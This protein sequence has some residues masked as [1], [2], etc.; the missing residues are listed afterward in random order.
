MPSI[1]NETIKKL[2]KE[3]LI[4]NAMNFTRVKSIKFLSLNTFKYVNNSIQFY[5]NIRSS[6]SPMGR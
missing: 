5:V 4:N 2:K 1:W 3:K 6:R